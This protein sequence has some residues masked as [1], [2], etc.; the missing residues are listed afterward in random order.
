MI[1]IV[2]GSRDRVIGSGDQGLAKASV[3]WDLQSVCNPNGHDQTLK[4][5][6]LG[7]YI[8]SYTLVVYNKTGKHLAYA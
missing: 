6:T 5:A 2:D 8:N 7:P 1:D 4:S 3:I